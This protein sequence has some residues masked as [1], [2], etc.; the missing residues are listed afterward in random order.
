M[1]IKTNRS[2]GALPALSLLEAGWGIVLSTI[3]ANILGNNTPPASRKISAPRG[4]T[5]F[6]GAEN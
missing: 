4:V 2:D 5:C 6:W 1:T 3:C